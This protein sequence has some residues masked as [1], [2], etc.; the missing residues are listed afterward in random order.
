MR[1]SQYFYLAI[2]FFQCFGCHQE[3]WQERPGVWYY[4]N[5]LGKRI[6]QSE[7]DAYGSS[8]IDGLGGLQQRVSRLVFGAY[9]HVFTYRCNFLSIPLLKYISSTVFPHIWISRFSAQANM[10]AQFLKKSGKFKF[11]GNTVEDMYFKKGILKKL[12]L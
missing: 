6:I 1:W 8:L 10:L 5:P 12:H 7:I 2:L 4:Q 11:W 9:I 3:K